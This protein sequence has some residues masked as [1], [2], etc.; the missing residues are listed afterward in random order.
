MMQLHKQHTSEKYNEIALQASEQSRARGLVE[1]LVEA[2]AEV[3]RGA[4]PALLDRVQSLRRSLNHSAERQGR[5]IKASRINEARAIDAEIRRITNEYYDLEAEIKAKT[6]GYAALTQTQPLTIREIQQQVID[7]DVLLLE[8]SLGNERSYVWAVTKDSVQTFELPRR[9]QI[10][11][12][13]RRLYDIL[14][15]P[16]QPEAQAKLGDVE[17]SIRLKTESQA[18]AMSLSRLVLSP[19]APLLGQKRLAIVSEG[20]LQY[21][22]F[23]VLPVVVDKTPAASQESP[24][25][26]AT[27][28]VISLPSAST[29][30]VIRRQLAGRKPAPKT[31]AVLADPVFETD[32]ER[33][34][35]TR[36]ANAA[37]SDT[38]PTGTADRPRLRDQPADKTLVQPPEYE[39]IREVGLR[40]EGGKIERLGFSYREAESLL[41]Q[42]PKEQS[43]RALGFDASRDTAVSPEL[44]NYRIVHF[45][46][47]GVFNS[48]HPELSGILLSR[49][50]ANGNRKEGFLRLHDIYNLTMPAELVVLSGCQTA[51][52]KDVK[53]EGLVGLTRGFMY[54]GAARVVASLWK[55]DDRATAEL[56]QKFYRGML[57]DGLPP[58]A[59]LRAAQLELWKSKRWDHPFYW[60]AFVLQGEW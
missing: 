52:G 6:P 37:K 43:R 15:R 46:T 23:G 17:E 12:A 30:G 42:V 20:M 50:D 11:T 45:A 10:E 34:H 27:N 1:L 19:V 48:T 25:L 39:A 14:T 59:A 60:G 53:G 51:L 35:L 3:R 5:L 38:Q 24:P 49:F 40:V 4:D 55:V 36:K 54:A 44:S 33:F 22:P 2:K 13:A 21:I 58:A 47:H 56:M 32:D 16:S 57:Q 29:L 41:A 26:I 28:A 8:Y 9:A 18:A 31:L 7:P